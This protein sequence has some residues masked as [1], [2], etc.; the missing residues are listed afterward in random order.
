MKDN[1]PTLVF[2]TGN[3]KKLKEARE[4]LKD[5][6]EVKSIKEF[7]DVED[8]WVED[9][10]TFSGNSLI[11]ARAVFGQLQLPVIADDSGLSVEALNNEPGVYSARYAGENASD[12][13]N[14]EL[15]LSNLGNE[16]NRTARFITAIS[17]INND[18][19]EYLFDGEILGSITHEPIGENGFG[20]DPIFIPKGYSE[21]FAQMDAEQKNSMSHRGK[22]LQALLAFLER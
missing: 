10:E 18:G 14:L 21:T 7:D 9:K 1:L 15:L 12:Q 5:F 17:Y 11:K 22:A 2:A 8:N 16:E 20:Y 3:Q 19:L 4:I 6:Y 13:D